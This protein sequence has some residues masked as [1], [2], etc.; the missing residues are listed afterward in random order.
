MGRALELAIA[1]WQDVREWDAVARVARK[2]GKNIHV[3]RVCGIRA[4]KNA[5]LPPGTLGRKFKRRAVFGGN[6]AAWRSGSKL[7][8]LIKGAAQR[9][10]K[11]EN[12]VMLM[13]VSQ[14]TRVR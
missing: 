14:V 7:S 9:A 13:G 12:Y 1:G 8:S 6:Q 11:S 10:K 3:A 5:E 2:D 4:D